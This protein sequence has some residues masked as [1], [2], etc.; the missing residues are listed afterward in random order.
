MSLYFLLGTLTSTGQQ[1]IHNNPD[2]VVEATR[3]I[4]VDG[5]EILGQYAV[6]G[7]Y[8]FLMMVEADDNDAV[9]RLS[10]EIGVGTGIHMETLPAI[11][12]GF[13]SERLGDDPPRGSTSVQRPHESSRE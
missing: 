3:G 1:L 2:L 11:A 12:I 10:L 4:R 9:A 7:R 6:L 13:L 8:D 5:A